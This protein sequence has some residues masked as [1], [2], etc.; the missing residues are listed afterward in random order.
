[1]STS[2]PPSGW[3][4]ALALAA[5]EAP[6]ALMADVY[7]PKL[8]ICVGATEAAEPP[9]P[10]P[11]LPPPP[12][13]PAPRRGG[14]PADRACPGGDRAKRQAGPGCRRCDRNAGTRRGGAFGRGR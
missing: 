11:L 14:P 6:P 10:P 12:P 1:M 3:I 8:W 9:P 5:A 4:E 2:A 7:S 13:P